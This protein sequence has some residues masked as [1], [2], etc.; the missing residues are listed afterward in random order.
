[1]NSWSPVLLWPIRNSANHLTTNNTQEATLWYHQPTLSIYI[2]IAK[3]FF[4]SFDFQNNETC[5]T[6]ALPHETTDSSE[7]YAHDV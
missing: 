3:Y 7:M 1:M 5:V 2:Y 6:Q 4:N